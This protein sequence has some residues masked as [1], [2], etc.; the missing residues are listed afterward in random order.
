MKSIFEKKNDWTDN[1]FSDSSFKS[2]F[3]KL[4]TK[5]SISESLT[6]RDEEVF[7]FFLHS[8]ESV[9]TATNLLILF[10]SAGRRTDQ[11]TRKASALCVSRTAHCACVVSCCTVTLS[12]LDFAPLRR[13]GEEGAFFLRSCLSFCFVRTKRKVHSLLS[14]A[15]NIRNRV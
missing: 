1:R 14:A 13:R 9:D 4:C 8:R 2:N 5:N 11:Q 15:V 6:R 3:L 7:F 10:D 12:C